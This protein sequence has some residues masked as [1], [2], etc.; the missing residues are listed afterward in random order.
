MCSLKKAIC[1]SFF[2][3][4][5]L[6]MQPIFKE[7][8]P[9]SGFSAYPDG[10]SS[11]FFRI[12]GV[13]LY[14][15]RKDH[16]KSN[17]ELLSRYSSQTTCK[18]L[19]FHKSHEPNFGTTTQWQQRLFLQMY[20]GRGV[21]LTTHLRLFLRIN[22]PSLRLY[23]PYIPSQQEKDNFLC[24][25]QAIKAISVRPMTT[26]LQQMTEDFVNDLGRGVHWKT[27]TVPSK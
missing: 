21:K 16:G 18:R 27:P 22:V 3:H 23:S 9:L 26:E 25:Q 20:D 7:K 10:S 13:I 8:I 19:I 11:L 1:R 4:F 24:T 5:K 12:N 6:P 2:S 15:C 14:L 17:P